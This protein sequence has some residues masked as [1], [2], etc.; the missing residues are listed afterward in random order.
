MQGVIHGAFRAKLAG[1]EGQERSVRP[2]LLAE[3]AKGAVLLP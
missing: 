2:G 3:G 1:V